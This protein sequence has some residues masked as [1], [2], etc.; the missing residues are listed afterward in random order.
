VSRA[1]DMAAADGRT[2]GLVGVV[3][4][5]RSAFDHAPI[6]MAVLTP[7]GHVIAANRALG[8]L[9][10]RDPTSLAGTTMFDVTHP[11]DLPEARRNC[12]LIQAGAPRIRRHE[13]RFLLPDGWPV[14]VLVSTARV[15]ASAGQ[16]EHLIM[17]I[18]DIGD[19]KALEAELIHR[20]LHDP[21]TGLANRTL[22]YQ[23]IEALA[24]ATADRRDCL[25]YLDL[26]GFKAVND[27]YG[28][29]AGDEL[30]Q[31]VAARMTALLRPDDVCARLGGD[32]F[33]VLSRGTGRRRAEAI[34]ARLREAVG[35]PYTL[36][37]DAV[38]VI[39]AATG[40]SVADRALPPDQWL[41]EADARMYEAKRR[42]AGT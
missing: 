27:A 30:L 1:G 34:A 18:E 21:L 41:R 19:R 9:L 8:D 25:I 36:D 3:P 10:C 2:V 11:E 12:E 37:G 29:A 7:T 24:A 13:C 39:T 4:D 28:H 23:R 5:L 40:I 32:E 14:W 33:A 20:A 15:P 38:V 17:H 26:D 22:L 35:R 6:G 42:R 16:A 31:Q